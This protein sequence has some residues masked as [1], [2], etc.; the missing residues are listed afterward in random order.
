VEGLGEDNFALLEVLGRPGAFVVP[1]LG[2]MALYQSFPMPAG[3]DAQAWRHVPAFRRP[4]HFHDE[5]ELNVVLGGKCTI[6]IGERNVELRT[7]DVVFFQPGQDHELLEDSADLDLFV[8]ALSPALAD[9]VGVRSPKKTAVLNIEPA[10]RSDL[11]HALLASGA[12][13]ESSLAN[14]ILADQ[15]RALVDRFESPHVLCRKAVDSMRADLGQNEELVA[16]RLRAHPSELSRVFGRELG[17]NLVTYR[18]RMRLIDFV[19]R[20]D[21]GQSLTAAALGAGFG[22]YS[23]CHRVFRAILGC[24]PRDY[25]KGQRQRLDAAVVPKAGQQ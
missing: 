8:L 14:A 2:A 11:A 20:A 6:G 21:D 22:S 16:R 7:G 15:F 17:L 24:S 23:Q 9:R 10:S 13:A 25:F 12:L 3:R 4:R 1:G 18:G 19:R 5:P